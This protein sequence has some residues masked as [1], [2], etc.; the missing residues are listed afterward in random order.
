MS[1]G[2]NPDRFP[3]VEAGLKDF[4]RSTVDYVFH[5]LYEDPDYTRRFL[6]AD[7]VGLGKTLVARGIISRAIWHLW[8]NVEHIDIVY[9]CSN[10]DIARQNINRLNVTGEQDFN[11]V[12]R[13]TLLPVKISSI[14]DRKLN[15]V[16]LTP[17]TSFDLRS[18]MGRKEERALLY[19][20]LDRAWGLEGAPPL[21]VL[22]GGV[23][24]WR[25]F[26]SYVRRFPKLKQIDKPLADLFAERL[27]RDER[28]AHREGRTSLRE[29]FHA[30]C[31]R[32]PRAR[33]DFGRAPIEH[34]RA[35]RWLIGKL[36]WELAVTCVEALKPDLVI[37]DEFQ[38]FKD[39]LTGEDDA[40][41]LAQRLFEFSDEVV[42]AR[43]LL[44]S[45]TPYKMYT[46]NGE[47]SDNDHYRDFLET[48]RFLQN[49]PDETRRT[50]RL[51]ERY[52]RQ[53]YRLDEETLPQL[54]PLKGRIEETLRRV[55]V[56]TERLSASKD[57]NGMLT[58]I[59][60][61]NTELLASDV[62]IYLSLQRVARELGR[63]ETLAYWKSA[64]YLLTFM[65]GYRLKDEFK[66][67][68]ERDNLPASVVETLS[69]DGGLALPWDRIRSYRTIETT[70]PRLRTLA[71]DVL[72]SGAWQ[73]LWIPPSF[74]Y[75][76][77][78]G[79]FA[80]KALRKF[81]KRL[82]F[83]AWRVV[84]KAVATLLS[85]GAERRIVTSWDPDAEN[86]R[87]RRERHHRPLQFAW[88]TE[89]QRLTGMPVLGILYPSGVLAR[90]CD[91]LEIAR[92]LAGAAGADAGG[93]PTADAVLE[94]AR[95]RIERRLA[96]LAARVVQESQGGLGRQERMA[97]PSDE[98]WYWAAPL[99]LDRMEAPEATSRWW[100]RPKL[101]GLWAGKEEEG[102]G[103]RWAEHVEEARRALKGEIR[104]G[105][106]PEDLV[107]VLSLIGV[108]GPSVAALRAL[109]RMLPPSHPADDVRLRDA[110]A[111]VGWSFRSLFNTVESVSLI[112]GLDDR[113]PFWRRMLEY[114]MAGNLQAVLDEYVH[115]LK[116][117][118]G[119]VGP[120]DLRVVEELA[121]K[122]RE[123][124]SLR[125][126]S[127][128]ADEI[129]V[130]ENIG[131][132]VLHEERMRAHFAHRFGDE[133]G[134][135][136]QA[137]HRA[138]QLRWA[139]NS[140]FWP[141]ILATTSFGQEGLDFHTY[142]HAIVHWNL[143]SN[144]VDMEQREG[145]IHRYKGHAV[146]R[147]LAQD[148]G[149]K[150]LADG[151]AK[152]DYKDPWSELFRLGAGV[153][154][155]DQTELVPFWVYTGLNG[156]G[157]ARIERHTPT[158]PLSR[159]VIRLSA[160]RRSLAV[161]RMVFGQ[162]RQEDLLGFLLEQLGEAQVEDW[163]EELRMDLGLRVGERP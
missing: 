118:L 47:S 89:R 36:R 3:D 78:T 159:D 49:D 144:P 18:N 77:P 25:K 56:R 48:V 161:Y 9:V 75:H 72:D 35:R 64:P 108:A 157:E 151:A 46:L 63:G 13:L 138:E 113:E 131:S 43:V 135:E 15:F 99:L 53:I 32:F 33:E 52:R 20:L 88:S 126:V 38:R 91:P 153:R 119:H 100:E 4:Q 134:T 116:E 61:G 80:D 65:E 92:K 97:G 141:F 28:E 146:R 8:D 127:L 6:V 115:V 44:L 85:Y 14:R 137:G 26:R 123:A 122:I 81:T 162:P 154:Q 148:F 50:A 2:M 60:G 133:S 70:N 129:S 106:P 163:L 54:Q 57:R 69:Q 7:E 17:G 150:V 90:I 107:E 155:A 139:F 68:L 130:D 95:N 73:L 132:I 37:L 87:E 19:H 152:R 121:E 112:R 39:L 114:G 34:R 30:V 117:A 74:P 11:L 79:P 104:L 111:Q 147:N 136:E 51:L 142:C 41:R 62:R 83:S 76:E 16:A 27:A 96:P 40:P 149:L 29:E 66:H 110:A 120:A 5:R 94:E 102:D 82:V 103:S 140:P 58:E 101:A 45:A 12:S 71:Q 84:P 143:P 156:N 93:L 105:S 125:T 160:L 31:A 86:T 124:L 67:R 55:M 109:R 42:E 1:N 24:D 98:T 128:K 22:Q 158:L 23:K 59:P 10:R 145:R 21:N